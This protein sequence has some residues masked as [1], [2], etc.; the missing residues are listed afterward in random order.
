M[1]R[2]DAQTVFDALCSNAAFLLMNAA[3]VARQNN[4]SDIDIA[5]ADA[6]SGLAGAIF[7]KISIHGADA[8]D[9]E[10]VEKDL[11][12]IAKKVGGLIEA[13]GTEVRCNTYGLFDASAFTKTFEIG[14]EN[15][16]GELHCARDRAEERLQAAE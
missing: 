1:T 14:F 11:L 9:Y 10:L 13:I 8:R 6:A 5:K 16:F 15:A 4:L 3:K 2:V 7:H 12:H